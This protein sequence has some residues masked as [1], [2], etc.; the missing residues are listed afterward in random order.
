MEENRLIAHLK[1]LKKD[2]APMTWRQRLDHLWTYYKW[3]LAVLVFLGFLLQIIITSAVNAN[4]EILISGIGINVPLTEQG[5]T[6]LSDGYLE[7]LDGKKGQS[8]QFLNEIL[9]KD[10]QALGTEAMYATVVKVSG[11]TSLGNL[12]YLLLDTKALEYYSEGDLFMD[13]RQILT[14]EELAQLKLVEIGGIP[15]LID[16][17][18]TW[19]ADTHFTG[20]GPYYLAF[21][22]N[23]SRIGQCYDLWLY[24][25]SGK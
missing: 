11:L 16:L 14:Q 1:K 20:E 24:L 9:D 13:L 21:T 23:T 3:V 12:D 22:F 15:K 19:F 18:G 17:S 10:D 6:C 25:N 7:R 2:L 8:V 4:T 5:I